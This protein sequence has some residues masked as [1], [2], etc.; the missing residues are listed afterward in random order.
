MSRDTAVSLP[1]SAAAPRLR[2]TLQTCLE[3]EHDLSGQKSAAPMAAPSDCH[4]TTTDPAVEV[5][6]EARSICCSR[7]AWGDLLALEVPC[8]E[9]ML[10]TTTGSDLG[11][12]GWGCRAIQ[13]AL[14]VRAF[15][16][17][18]ESPLLHAMGL[19]EH[20]WL[21]HKAYTGLL[22]RSQCMH[23]RGV[24]RKPHQDRM[25]LDV[26]GCRRARLEEVS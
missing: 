24:Q 11:R 8:W 15:C 25:T 18:E 13:P 12:C 22:R 7:L 21:R 19:V 1:A 4:Q 10:G 9:Y 20:P 17:L 3:A 2:H 16:E 6:L 26:V 23:V 14:R 5:A